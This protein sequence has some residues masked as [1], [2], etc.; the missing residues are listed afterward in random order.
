MSQHAVSLTLFGFVP[1]V[2]D[3]NDNY[4]FVFIMFIGSIWR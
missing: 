2:V 1:I 3:L 4:R